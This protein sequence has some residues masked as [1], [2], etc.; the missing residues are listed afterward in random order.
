MN[1]PILDQAIIAN[2]TAHQIYQHDTHTGMTLLIIEDL[3]PIPPYR[4]KE[5][6]KTTKPKVPNIFNADI[7]F[8]CFMCSEVFGTSKAP[9]VYMCNTCNTRGEDETKNF[10]S[11]RL[12]VR[13]QMRDAGYHELETEYLTIL[14]AAMIKAGQLDYQQ[15]KDY[16]NNVL[17]NNGIERIPTASTV[18][19]SALDEA[20]PQAPMNLSLDD[21][22]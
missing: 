6:I 16:I 19:T 12:A 21:V 3:F 8:M 9:A 11:M 5:Q 22:L 10:A 13:E 18:D 14:Y 20:L 1:L 7:P 17:E 4:T 15:W 2:F